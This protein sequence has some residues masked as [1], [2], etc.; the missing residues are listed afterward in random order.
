MCTGRKQDEVGEVTRRQWEIDHLLAVNEGRH[1]AALCLKKGS[2]LRNL[3]CL[4]LTAHREIEIDSERRGCCQCH[5]APVK[6]LKTGFLRG[7]GVTSS[8]QGRCNIIPIF[9]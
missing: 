7:D 5:S 9:V 4:R 3:H 1:D 6:L 2:L 8:G